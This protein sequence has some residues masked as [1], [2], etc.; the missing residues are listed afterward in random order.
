MSLVP[1]WA[2]QTPIRSY[3]IAAY[4]DSGVLEPIPPLR[5]KAEC[6]QEKPPAYYRAN[7]EWQTS[8]H[9]LTLTPTGNLELPINQRRTSLGLWEE[10]GKH[11]ERPRRPTKKGPCLESSMQRKI[12]Q[13]ASHWP[14]DLRQEVTSHTLC[15]SPASRSLACL[16]LQT[17]SSARTTNPPEATSI[18]DK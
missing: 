14:G 7:T 6:T 12:N 11:G 1:N 9:T 5:A 3:S 17:F 4:V 15:C 8:T 18:S 16:S 2:K 13:N 10:G